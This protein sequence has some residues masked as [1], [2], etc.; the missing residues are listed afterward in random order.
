MIMGTTEKL[1]HLKEILAM[2]FLN[3]TDQSIAYGLQYGYKSFPIEE[4][5]ARGWCVEISVKEAGYGERTIQSLRFNRPDNIDAKNMEYNVL[6]ELMSSLTM[7]SMLTWYETAK[8]LASDPELQ[9]HI[10]DETKENN[11]PSY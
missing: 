9:K 2:S 7:C 11:K 10:I 8:M 1:K 5:E 6:L 3:A 4:G